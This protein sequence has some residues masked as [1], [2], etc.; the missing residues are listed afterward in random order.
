MECKFILSNKTFE[1][2][3]AIYLESK[4][5]ISQINERRE[6]DPCVSLGLLTRLTNAQILVS[7]ISK[8]IRKRNRYDTMKSQR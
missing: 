1:E 6:K 2:L 5:A 4:W 8:E 3:V 7:L